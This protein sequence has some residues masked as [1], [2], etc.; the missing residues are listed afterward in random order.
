MVTPIRYPDYSSVSSQL[1]RISVHRHSYRRSPP[2]FP[3][4]T[5]SGS[6]ISLFSNNL[7]VKPS[8]SALLLRLWTL[9]CGVGGGGWSS[10]PQE[11]GALGTGKTRVHM[12]LRHGEGGLWEPGNRFRLDRRG[13]R[14]LEL[15]K[16]NK[17]KQLIKR[18]GAGRLDSR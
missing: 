5:L 1:A 11:Q 15:G 4:T 6:S 16:E 9:V 14:G 17:I 3:M 7:D 2:L 8:K 13:F 12:P 10:R 18:R